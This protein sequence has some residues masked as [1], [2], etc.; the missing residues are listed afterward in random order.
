MKQCN[1]ILITS[2]KGGVGK[3]TVSSNLAYSLAKMGKTVLL[4]DM[5][6]GNRSLDIMLGYEDRTLF[7]ISDVASGAVPAERA[8]ITSEERPGMFFCAAPYMYNGSVTEESFASALA[9]LEKLN[10]VIEEIG[11]YKAQIKLQ[12]QSFMFPDFAEPIFKEMFID[13]IRSADD[14][15]INASGDRL[16]MQFFF[17]LCDEL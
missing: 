9:E 4:V 16:T 2:C 5:D 13:L 12:G 15:A 17:D 10:I 8:V 3:S 1:R 14:L 7:D 6:L 11:Q